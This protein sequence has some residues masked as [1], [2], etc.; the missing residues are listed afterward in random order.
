MIDVEDLRQR[1]RSADRA[2]PLVF[3]NTTVELE[4]RGRTFKLCSTI[5]DDFKISTGWSDEQIGKEIM[6]ILDQEILLDHR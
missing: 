6:A 5:V 3:N 2:H 4:Y 1:G